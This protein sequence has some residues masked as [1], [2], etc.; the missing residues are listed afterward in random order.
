MSLTGDPDGP[1]YRLGLPVADLVAGLF[2]VQGILLALIA[3]GTNGRGRHVDI[4]MLDSV[5][6]LLTYQAANY[7][8]TGHNPPRMGNAHASIVPYGTFDTRD[9][10][11][12]L[13]VGNDDQ[14]RRFCDATGLYTLTDKLTSSPEHP[15]KYKV[16]RFGTYGEIRAHLGLERLTD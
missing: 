6:G 10:Q 11:L 13:A 2:A 5:A 8:T 4:S 3:R 14:W 16:S 7:L 12:M 9:G 15:P 1:P